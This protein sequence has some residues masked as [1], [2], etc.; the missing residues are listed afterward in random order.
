MHSHQIK[1]PRR[2]QEPASGY[3]SRHVCRHLCLR[4][5]VQPLQVFLQPPR[6]SIIKSRGSPRVCRVA[7]ITCG[8]ARGRTLRRCCAA[9]PGSHRCRPCNARIPSP[10]HRCPLPEPPLRRCRTRLLRNSRNVVKSLQRAQCEALMTSRMRGGIGADG[11]RDV[12]PL[13][14]A[15]QLRLRRGGC[16]GD[17]VRYSEC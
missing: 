1:G 3:T 17:F 16:K 10:L 14:C 11:V 6:P 12:T 4:A 2:L 5:R 7:R 15:N 13:G 9:G 8:G